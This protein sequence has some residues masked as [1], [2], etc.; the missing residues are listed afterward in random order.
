VTTI[1]R[2]TILL[3]L[4]ACLVAVGCG[5]DDEG[6]PIPADTA[7]QLQTRMDEIERRFDFGNGACG[8][9]END[10]RPA[11]NEL[12]ASMPDDVDADVRQ[13]VQEGFDRLFALSEDQCEEEQQTEEEPQTT[14]QPEPEP[15]ATV[16]LPP[17]TTETTP[18]VETEEEPPPQQ[19]EQ[20]VPP[21]QDGVPPGQGGDAPNGGEGG[22]GNSGQGG[23]GSGQNGAQGDGGG[24]VVPEGDG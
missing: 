24:A 8:D 23:S 19:E 15:P 7:D 17:E 4:G 2:T 21:G 22:D 14:P 5:S 11:V 3:M 16:T 13:G 1:K 9:I 18:P 20:G 6:E 12:I 10:S